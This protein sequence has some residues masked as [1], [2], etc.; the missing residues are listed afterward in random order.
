MPVSTSSCA[1]GASFILVLLLQVSQA[2]HTAHAADLTVT[3]RLRPLPCA[4]TLAPTTVEHSALLFQHLNRNSPTV[5]EKKQV[6]LHVQCPAARRFS[7]TAKDNQR[8]SANLALAP[9]ISFLANDSLARPYVRGL[10]SINGQR[11]GAYALRLVPDN[12]LGVMASDNFG[13]WVASPTGAFNA[14]GADP[15]AFARQ[16]APAALTSASGLIEIETVIEQSSRLSGS[17]AVALEGSTTLQLYY[18]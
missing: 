15:L 8:A 13:G 10:G 12:G 5:L 1:L 14:V 4:I 2:I 11:I 9:H 7:M 3:A 16:G 6:A 17:D 18:E